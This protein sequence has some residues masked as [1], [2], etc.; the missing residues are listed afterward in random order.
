[1]CIYLIT[2]GYHYLEIRV[3]ASGMDGLMYHLHGEL[4]VRQSPSKK[5]QKV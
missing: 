1:M 3:S 4:P 2:R 5:G